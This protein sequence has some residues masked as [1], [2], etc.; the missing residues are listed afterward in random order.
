VDP[1]APEYPFYTPYQFAGNMPIQ[2]IDRDG[3]EPAE[4]PYMAKT[5]E[6][7]SAPAKGFENLGNKSWISDGKEWGASTHKAQ[8]G[9]TNLLNL[10][11][12]KPAMSFGESLKNSGK[13]GYQFLKIEATMAAAY[14]GIGEIYEAGVGLVSAYKSF[15]IGIDAANYYYD[16]KG[17]EK[18]DILKAANIITTSRGLYE[19]NKFGT[20]FGHLTDFDEI[21]APDKNHGAKLPSQSNRINSL[22]KK[23]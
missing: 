7:Y 6:I 15:D 23:H 3:L 5:D 12:T 16:F 4:A 8:E 20:K 2:F 17:K 9:I 14:T 21:F 10:K 13:I 1:L 22:N 19:A 18:P 11:E